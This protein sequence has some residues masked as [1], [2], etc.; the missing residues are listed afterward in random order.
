M[1]KSKP[2]PE[3]LK[4]GTGSDKLT[5]TSIK[6]YFKPLT[7]WLIVQRNTTGYPKGWVKDPQPTTVSPTTKPSGS[8]A[9]G[10]ST[11]NV[12]CIVF[13]LVMCFLFQHQQQQRS[14]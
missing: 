8:A 13:G 12:M 1:G 10:C 9:V 5:A 14:Q 2:W 7:E 6:E 3:A 11:V 4:K